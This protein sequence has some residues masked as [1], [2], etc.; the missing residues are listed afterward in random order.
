M[1]GGIGFDGVTTG[2]FYLVPFDAGPFQ[3]ISPDELD[4]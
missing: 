2:K 1:I 4:D 3:G